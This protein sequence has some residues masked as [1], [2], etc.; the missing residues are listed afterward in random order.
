MNKSNRDPSTDDISDAKS[1]VASNISPPMQD[2][3]FALPKS[4]SQTLDLSLT[5][6]KTT[7]E[8]TSTSDESSTDTNAPNMMLPGHKQSKVFSCNFCQRKFFSSQALGGH[9]NAHK[10]ERS[11]ARRRI[12]TFPY[13]Y[14]TNIAS[15]PLHGSILYSPLGIEAHSLVTQP[16]PVPVPF[17]MEEEGFGLHWPG[18]YRDNSNNERHSNSNNATSKREEPDLTLRL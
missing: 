13:A 8:P 2:P 10:R 4:V 3:F 15:L 17:Y 12:S 5:L 18:S 7:K 14:P 6:Y 16:I 9:Q 1:H 11:I